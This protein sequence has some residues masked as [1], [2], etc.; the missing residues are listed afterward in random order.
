M[1]RSIDLGVLINASGRL[2]R[3]CFIMPSTPFVVSHDSL[4]DDGSSI[5]CARARALC[6]VSL[7]TGAVHLIGNAV[8]GFAETEILLFA[9]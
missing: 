5:A 9:R 8:I 1:K 7:A 3:E 4:D 6:S 2:A